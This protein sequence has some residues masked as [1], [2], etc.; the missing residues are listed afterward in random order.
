MTSLVM[1]IFQSKEDLV[2]KEV[3]EN[4]LK[5]KRVYNYDEHF[6][7]QNAVGMTRLVMMDAETLYPY[8]GLLDFESNFDAKLIQE[9]FYDVLDDIPHEIMVTDGYNAY[10]SII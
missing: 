6:P 8:K 1:I 9:Y 7:H 10:P 4:Q 2:E 3:E 5:D